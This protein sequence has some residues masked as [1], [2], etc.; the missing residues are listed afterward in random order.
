MDEEQKAKEL[1]R[2]SRR[3]FLSN[4]GKLAAGATAAAAGISL[5]ATTGSA[6]AETPTYPWPYKKL[7][8]E[9][10]Y[11][12][13][14]GIYYKFGCSQ[15]T[16]E[17]ILSELG[18]PFT[19]IPPVMMRY[20]GGGV[21]G[22]GSHCGALN[23]SSAAISLAF[24]ADYTKIINELNGWY[25]QELGSGSPLCHISVT[26]WC[27][28]NGVTEDS[29]DR[30]DRCARVTG[31][32]AKKAVLLM[33]AQ[34]DGQFQATWSPKATTTGCKSCHGPGGRKDVPAGVVQD[35]VM[36]HGNKHQ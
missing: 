11:W 3:G 36:C 35:C 7:D 17:A 22:W 9:A 16:L 32:T 10:V 4:A 13:A 30:I 6:A 12:K 28:A 25:V 8:P 33:N 1:A 31:E 27:K 23:G 34:A 29:Q 5:L 2:L 18:S 21:V 19:T 15:G 14:Y 24:P 26:E 20:G